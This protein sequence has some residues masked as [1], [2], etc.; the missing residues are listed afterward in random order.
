M[1]SNIGLIIHPITGNVGIGT[2]LPRTALDV[3]QGIIV[4]GNVGIGTTIPTSSLHVMGNINMVGTFKQSA[5]NSSFIRNIYVETDTTSRSFGT[6]YGVGMTWA[7]R[8]YNANSRLLIDY[9]IPIRND[10]GSWGGLYTYVE[11]NLNGAG[12]AFLGHSG[13]TGVMSYGAGDIGF[14][15]NKFWFPFTLASNFT[16]QL[17][18]QHR[19][20]DG[21]GYVNQATDAGTGTANGFGIDIYQFFSKL[22]IIEFSP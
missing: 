8:T 4:G 20:Y 11:Y 6:G 18:F 9:Y 3:R 16:F 5:I 12:W 17:R 15:T 7:S 13:Y 1:S 2:T 22:I 21:T 19:T 10:S 14:H